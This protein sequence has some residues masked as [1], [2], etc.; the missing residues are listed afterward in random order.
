MNSKVLEIP[1][2]TIPRKVKTSRP[3]ED[4]AATQAAN[5]SQVSVVSDEYKGSPAGTQPIPNDQSPDDEN[6]VGY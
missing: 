5:D 6:D 2:E 4:M 1:T 3:F